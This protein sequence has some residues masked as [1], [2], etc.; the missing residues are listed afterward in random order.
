MVWIGFTAGLM[1]L[2]A[3]GP[4]ACLAAE[5]R[6]IG[7]IAVPASGDNVLGGKFVTFDI[8]AF[9]GSTQINYVSDRSNAAIDIFSAKTDRYVGRIGGK[10]HLFTGQKATNQLSGPNGLVIVDA[11]PRR[12]LFAGN[13]DST[14]MGFEIGGPG[15]NRQVATIATGRAE[16]NRVDEIAFDPA[17]QT[18]LAGNNG[19]PV[20]FATLLDMHEGPAFGS[21]RAKIVFDGSNNAGVSG[22]GIE[23]AT[24]NAK[25]GSFF[26]AIQHL[27][28]GDA[29]PGGLVEI[30][31]ASGRILRVLDFS[32]AA[33]G[34]LAACAPSGVSTAESGQMLVGCAVASQSFV[35]EPAEGGRTVATFPQVSGVDQIDYDPVRRRWF[36]AARLNPGGPVLGV[37]DAATNTFLQNVPTA[38]NA[39]SV[40]VDPVSGKVF[41]P[42][43]ADATNKICADGCIG[44]FAE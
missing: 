41:V 31:P 5:Y 20:H 44:V 17:A 9:D 29:D 36:L 24:Y 16:E 2:L 15:E 19:A 34:R 4:A 23:A 39:H 3:A 25:T 26:L 33:F 13:A 11:G 10:G 38:F 28:A 42:L 7:T 1:I 40:A 18:M 22:H 37:V 43:G 14:V 30:D 12:L 35:V 8:G 6:L 21:V 27:A 32:T